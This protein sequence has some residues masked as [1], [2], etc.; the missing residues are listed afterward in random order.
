MN[1]KNNSIFAALLSVA[2]MFTISVAQES[3]Q[4]V[5]SI[6]RV[7]TTAAQFLKIGA[8]ARPIG[9]GGAYTA[10]SEDILSVYW[11]PA[12]LSR[13]IGSGEAA[14]NHANWLAETSYDFAAFSF[15]IGMIGSFGFHFI[16]FR[17]PEQPVRTVD[18]PDGTGQYWSAN[19][20]SLGLTYA[21]NLTDQFSIGFTGKY[22]QEKIF[23]ESAHGAAV[24]LGIFYKTPWKNLTLG[25]AIFNFGTKMHMDG[26]DLYNNVD[27]EAASGSVDAVAA[28]YRTENFD[29]PLSLRFGI[30]WQAVKNENLQI[31]TAVDGVQ[32]NDNS[33][34]LNS[35]LEIGLRR[36][37]YLRG[38]YKA[39]FQE[40]SEQ[41]LTFG[42]GIRYDVVGTHLK[43]DFGWADYGRLN[44]VQF[45][46]LGIKY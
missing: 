21:K 14:F 6:N 37:I 8:G 39:L 9:M 44:N 1:L 32:P 23:N 43:F 46:S 12:G 5:S 19:M 20:V 13:I 38:G 36:V 15:N 42:A 11:N 35:G 26:S 34:Y 24:D 17:T 40:N 33:Q 27:P 4:T 31:M 25:A 10:V 29:M 18:L 22:V 16:S 3:S 45:V 7:G 2:V 30:A 28:K 41:G